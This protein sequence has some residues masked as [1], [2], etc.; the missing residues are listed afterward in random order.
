MDTLLLTRKE[1]EFLLKP[2]E[3]YP[4]L[5]SAFC[6]YSLNHRIPAQRARS[7]LPQEK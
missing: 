1:V 3:L 6:S 5:E 7:V 2:L 4:A